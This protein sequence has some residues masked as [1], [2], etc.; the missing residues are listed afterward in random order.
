[1]KCVVLVGGSST[2][3]DTVFKQ[4][5]LH[6][7]C[8]E[9]VSHTTRPQRENE[10]EGK[11]YYFIS[12]DEFNKMVYEKEFIERRTYHTEFGTWQYGLSKKAINPNS[13]NIYVA[14]LDLQGLKQLEEYIGKENVISIYLESLP[15]TRLI[16]SIEREKEKI[17]NEALT[18]TTKTLD[19]IRRRLVVDF[20]DFKK[21]E[22]YCD[23]TLPNETKEDI[24]TIV[25]C[26]CGLIY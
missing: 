3:K 17:N 26:I 25:S 21:A 7:I 18:G 13:N 22:Y 9:A 19:E 5:L 14:I 24:D 1:M 12:D 23:V 4:L 11:E 6:D 15:S 16:R 2:G 10:T 20:N 8:I